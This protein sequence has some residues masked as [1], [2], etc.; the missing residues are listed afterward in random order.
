MQLLIGTKKIELEVID[1]K[2]I[3][4]TYDILKNLSV[5]SDKYKPTRLEKNIAEISTATYCRLVDIARERG[6]AHAK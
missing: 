6:H 3:E 4:Y 5:I 2:G 1:E